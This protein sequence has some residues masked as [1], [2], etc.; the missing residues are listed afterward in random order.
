MWPL[1]SGGQPQTVAMHDAPVKEVAWIP[2]MNLL[3]SGSWDKT[4]R[5]ALAVCCSKS[6]PFSLGSWIHIVNWCSLMMLPMD[7]YYYRMFFKRISMLPKFVN[8]FDSIPSCLSFRSS[9]YALYKTHGF[10]PPQSCSMILSHVMLTA[11]M[12]YTYWSLSSHWCSS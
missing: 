4:L 1:L 8:V 5:C 2:Q 11:A 6:S 12:V 10:L 3:V 9:L 7:V